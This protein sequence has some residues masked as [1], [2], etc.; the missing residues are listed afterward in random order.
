MRC[1][2]LGGMDVV[3]VNRAPCN[4]LGEALGKR[5]PASLRAVTSGAPVHL[6]DK[7][8]SDYSCPLPAE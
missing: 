4:N 2:P 1:L 7:D 5:K 8:R 6:K 3:I